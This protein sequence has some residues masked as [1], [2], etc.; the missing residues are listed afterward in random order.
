ML[1][2]LAAE[3]AFWQKAF[4]LD[5]WTIEARHVEDLRYPCNDAGAGYPAKGERMAGL[6]TVDR[7][8][9]S[10]RIAVR[11][12]R[13]MRQLREWPEAVCHEVMHVLGAAYRMAGW[14]IEKEHLVINIVAPML[15]KA[16]RKDPA[17]AARTAG[18]FAETC[19]RCVA[20]PSPP[21]VSPI[22]AEAERAAAMSVSPPA[23]G[24]R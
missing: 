15:V 7:N 20:A 22:I 6:C 13:T 8:A 14:S 16:K 11:R 18:L 3:V 9:R 17:L 21:T 19:R 10:A 23:C 2:N 24:A 1:P 5:D 4:G 12:P